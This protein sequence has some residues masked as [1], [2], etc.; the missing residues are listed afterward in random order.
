[1]PGEDVGADL[2]GL[3]SSVGTMTSSAVPW[4]REAVVYEVYVRSFAD[5][6]G[7]GLGDLEG[8][9][10][11]LGYLRDLGVDAVWITPFYP[12]PQRDHGYD[13]ADYCDVDPLFGDLADFDRL[14]ADAHGL[15][16]RVIVDVVPN[17]TS[18]EHPWFQAALGE[19]ASAERARYWFR[20]GRGADGDEPPNN[21]QSVFGGPAWTRDEGSRQWY[22]HMF[23]SSQPDLD[24]GNREVHEEFLRILRFWLDRGV[25]G[26]RIDVAHSLYVRADLADEPVAVGAKGLHDDDHRHIWDQDE[27]LAVYEEWR[28]VLDAYAG[29]RMLVGE[30]FLFDV[31]RVAQYVGPTRLHQAFNFTVFKAQWDP[32][33]L[34]RVLLDALAGFDPGTWVLSNHDLTRHVTRYGGGDLGRR[35]GLAVSGLVFALPG[36][37]YLYQGEELGLDETDVPDHLRED[38]VFL[39]TAGVMAGRDGCRTPLPWE[40]AAP[41]H[42]FTDGTPWLPFGPDASAQAVDRQESDPDSVL[43]TY[44]RLLARRRA[45]LPVLG[46]ALAWLEAPDEVLAVRRGPLVA[47]LNTAAEPVELVVDDATQLLEATAP[48]AALVGRVV[49]VPAAATVWVLV[50]AA[51]GGL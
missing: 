27:V 31:P 1:M 32:A 42:G 16:L 34:R 35:R 3:E 43:S 17:H 26:F 13:V 2:S 49:T 51:V 50:G 4:W 28:Q 7:D 9:R 18:S 24:W 39:R 10:S 33:Q 46:D 47:V 21:W 44:R 37:P 30:V 38:P 41:G 22:L 23:D 29:D 5:S 45:L 14:L 40:A 12:S 6:D 19:Q 20:D 15:G 8:I 25:D 11:K 48:G 36:S